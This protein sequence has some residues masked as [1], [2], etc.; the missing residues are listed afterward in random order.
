M[1]TVRAVVECPV[2][3]SF[4]VQQVAGLFDVPIAARARETFTVDVPDPT[5]PWRIGAIVGPS[6][7][8]KTT[9]ACEAFG[10]ALYTAPP[11]PP[12]RAVVDAFDDLPI[13]TITHTLSAVGFSSP[14]SWIK[15]Y[16]A[17]SN[18]ERFRCDLARA[19]LQPGDLTAYDEFTSVVDR[20]V[21]KVGSVA[22]AKSIR[23]GRIPKRFVAVSCHYDI[24][25]WLCPDW[26][27]D[28]ATCQLARGC[29]WRGPHLIL[30]VYPVR[31][32]AW[33]LFKRHHYLSAELPGASKC[34]VGAV[35]DQPG[36]FVAVSSMMGHKGIRRISRVVT[37][38]DFQ[39]V[40]LAGAILRV[41]AAEHR[42]RG[43]RVRIVTG[44]PAMVRSLSRSR[45]WRLDD[46]KRGGHKHNNRTLPG[47]FNDGKISKRCRRGSRGRTVASFEFVGRPV[48]ATA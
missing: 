10:D 27:V 8:G 31:A 16:A 15:P 23:C 30:K 7:S 17:L 6:G 40:G 39:G 20:T 48:A 2:F 25:D 19:L 26:V 13:K 14:P 37:L 45:H 21:A 3:D 44:H 41:V 5:D 28:M 34:Y 35:D 1:Q 46:L 47:S 22:I 43:L 12:D 32:A 9:I 29:L 11:W 36:V 4:R 33:R 38:P 42:R 24:L 18:G